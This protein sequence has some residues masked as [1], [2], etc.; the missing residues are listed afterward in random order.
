MNQCTM[1]QIPLE[2]LIMILEVMRF[3]DSSNLCKA[4]MLSEQLAYRYYHYKNEDL[5]RI[6]AIFRVEKMPSIRQNIAKALFQ[7]CGFQAQAE[8]LD[9]IKY[10]I[11][12]QDLDLF[13][14]ALEDPR[15]NHNQWSSPLRMACEYGSLDAVKLLVNDYGINI[16]AHENA[17]L[18]E[19]SRGHIDI[20]KYILSHPDFN[21]ENCS[22]AL[23]YASHDNVVRILLSDPRVDPAYQNNQAIIT[24]ANYGYLEIFK[25]L[26]S[27]PRV[28]PSDQNNRAVIIAARERRL[29]IVKL[30]LKDPRVNP[31]DENN[32]AI[33]H[34]ARNTNAEIVKLILNDPRVDPSDQ[35]N[36]AIICAVRKRD[37]EIVKLLLA[38]PR[39][40]P[41]DQ[42]NKA[43]KLAAE[44]ELFEILK[45]LLMD[46]RICRT[47]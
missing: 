23:T 16:S 33:I 14:N 17:G 12:S 24:A 10:S 36:L 21:P 31:S 1:K 8:V 19:A 37:E 32:L 43:I 44:N 38:D 25:L 27:D 9:K 7:N 3:E 30:L 2:I 18:C 28:N 46:P 40:N 4:L 47:Q 41:S 45:L 35:E 29:E 26:L 11:L 34:A 5:N 6:N 22:K 13:I 15:V 39:V 20:V 42:R